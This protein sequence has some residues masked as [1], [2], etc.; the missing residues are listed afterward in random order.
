V[1]IL[2]VIMNWLTFKFGRSYIFSKVP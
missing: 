1:V 2:I